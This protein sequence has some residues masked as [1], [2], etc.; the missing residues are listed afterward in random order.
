MAN[1]SLNIKSGVD[2]EYLS[3]QALNKSVQVP[4]GAIIS[5]AEPY[6]KP[7]TL[8]GL[9]ET[10]GYA[11]CDGRAL[12][13]YTYRNL[14]S[15]ISNKYGG[16]A[17]TDGVTNIAGATTTFNVPDLHSTKNFIAG[18]QEVFY[19]YSSLIEYTLPTAF[20]G[21][22]IAW[23]LGGSR[24]V[25]VGNNFIAYSTSITATTA[26]FT[27]ITLTGKAYRA[28]T[29]DGSQFIAVGSQGTQGLVSTSPDGVTWT[30]QLITTANYDFRKIAYGNG[31]YAIK[32]SVFG[33]GERLW[34]SSDALTWTMPTAGN[35]YTYGTYTNNIKFIKNI[36]IMFDPSSAVSY[37]SRII[38]FSYDLVS[39]TAVQLP[40]VLT[41]PKYIQS[42]VDVQYF[43][44]YFHFFHGF[45][46]EIAIT[47]DFNKISIVPYP[48]R[49][50]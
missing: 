19:D 15:V 12:N 5:S 2:I 9:D 50:V 8:G 40:A 35:A 49:E 28:I 16:T 23:V 6:F 13:T 41:D 31:K 21:D 33:Q 43:N 3:S 32:S 30:H 20:A 37:Q 36:F 38:Y 42:W 29:H 4:T 44:N 17:F 39:W 10:L 26:S 14:H 22:P 7:T 48:V 46:N 24:V 18:S 27:N 1:E 45:S 11:P 25:V 47:K 34:T